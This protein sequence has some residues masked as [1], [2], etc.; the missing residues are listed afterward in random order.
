MMQG[1][2]TFRKAERLC[3]KKHIEA[4][5]AGDNRSLTA[6]PLR[7]V[8]TETE[9][10]HYTTSSLHHSITSSLLISVSKRHF[11]RAVHRNRAKRQIRE[12]YRLNKEVLRS[13]VA[14][15]TSL[16]IALIWLAD[17]PMESHRVTKSV[18]TILHRLAERQV[19]KKTE[20]QVDK[21][22]ERP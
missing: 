6:Y 7:A 16:A 18:K 4:L 8:Y 9:P 5:F 13:V 22:T 12:A 1:R 20:R 15:G 11:K 14:D 10:P 21:K 2:H 19:G 3:S 17:E